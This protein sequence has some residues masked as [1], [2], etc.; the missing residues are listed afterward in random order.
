M[1]QDAGGFEQPL[2]VG[3]QRLLVA[4]HFELDPVRQAHLAAQARGADGLVGGVAGRRIRQK[5]EL[6]AVDIVQQGFFGAIGQIHAADRHRDHFGARGLVAACHFGKAAVLAGA[7]EQA[8]VELA[9][10]D[11][12]RVHTL[13]FKANALASRTSTL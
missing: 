12:E 5:E 2:V 13:Y 4:D 8:G 1:H 3:K 6:G 10:G 11:G 7:H 9:S